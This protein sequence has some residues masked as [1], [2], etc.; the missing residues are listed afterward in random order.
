VYNAKHGIIVCLQCQTSLSAGGPKQWKK[1]LY[2]APHQLKGERVVAAI[3]LI[4]SAC[5]D[6]KL[7]R[8]VDELRQQ[9]P[10]RRA[11]CPRTDGLAAYA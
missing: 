7:L 6:G 5:A 11:P 2:R 8:S 10:R 1:H 9:W 4:A 3:S